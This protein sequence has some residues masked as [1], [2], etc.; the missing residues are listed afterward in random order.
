MWLLFMAFLSS[1]ELFTMPLRIDAILNLTHMSHWL[2]L[3]Q[4]CWL[5]AYSTCVVVKAG[6]KNWALTIK[7]LLFKKQVIC[8]RLYNQKT[9]FTCF[10]IGFSWSNFTCMWHSCH[11]FYHIYFTCFARIY[12][13]LCNKNWLLGSETVF[14][15]LLHC[16]YSIFRTFL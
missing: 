10:H 15:Q 1:K 4:R 11:F 13:C 5:I 3:E 9:I 6:E 12:K 14:T 16:V 8:E 7:N 2:N